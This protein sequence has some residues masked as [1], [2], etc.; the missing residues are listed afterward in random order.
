[1]PPRADR[2]PVSRFRTVLPHGYLNDP[3]GPVQMGN[4]THDGLLAM[5][6]LLRVGLNTVL[7]WWWADPLAGLVLIYYA[8]REAMAIFTPG[9]PA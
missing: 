7:S 1:M 2:H 6:V 8:I 4:T 9:T 5:V 3:N